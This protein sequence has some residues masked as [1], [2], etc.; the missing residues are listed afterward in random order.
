MK[1]ISIAA[2]V[3]A[4]AM[5]LSGCMHIGYDVEVR[6][7]GTASV[8]YTFGYSKEY[9]SEE[10]LEEEAAEHELITY[11]LGDKEYL[12][13]TEKEDFDSYQKLADAM[14]L[15]ESEA[16]EAEE[17]AEEAE[18]EN[19]ME[20][21]EEEGESGMFKSWNIVQKKSFFTTSY[22]FDAVTTQAVDP[23]QAE[24]YE[25]SPSDMMAVTFKLKMP[26]TMKNVTGG[27]VETD[28]KAEFT[29]DVS[30]ENTFHAES[31]VLNTTN[32]LICAVV[33]L[34]VVIVLVVLLTRKKGGNPDGGSGGYSGPIEYGTQAANNVQNF[35]AQASNDVQNFASQ[36][37]SDAH[38][39]ASQAAS[40]MQ[41]FG[42]QAA[43]EVQDAAA[44]IADEAK[45]ITDD[46][47]N[48]L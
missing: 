8:E 21:P 39:F 36:A 9:F 2:A 27:T 4:A 33:V 26:G 15:T 29:F 3:A 41:S 46:V 22:T 25:V 17:E 38:N 23:T 11:T 48:T 42:T 16:A 47:N 5:L 19:E 32:L 10:D 31:S 7:N 35:G 44:Q 30:A 6:D 13:Y 40:E 37:A 12:G 28:G 14:I 34:A 24:E 43:G 1:R 45:N 18:A 20:S